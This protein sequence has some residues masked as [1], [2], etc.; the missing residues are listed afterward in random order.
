MVNA[1]KPA[2]LTAG[3]GLLVSCTSPKTPLNDDN[4]WVTIAVEGDGPFPPN[5][6]SA[7]LMLGDT[8]LL[9]DGG[10][11]M[12][13]KLKRA[14]WEPVSKAPTRPNPP[15]L[16]AAPLDRDDPL[17]IGTMRGI[18]YKIFASSESRRYSPVLGVRGPSIGRWARTCAGDLLVAPASVSS[19]WATADSILASKE[20]LLVLSRSADSVMTF[21]GFHA[22]D[23]KNS[24]S[25]SLRP[26]WGPI[27]CIGSTEY[28]MDLFGGSLWRRVGP[29]SWDSVG[30]IDPGGR[31]PRTRERD[32]AMF[33]EPLVLV[34]TRISAQ[35]FAA[36]RATEFE[37]GGPIWR[38]DP[39]L[40]KV[41]GYTVE[42]YDSALTCRF[43][44]RL[45]PSVAW[46]A[47]TGNDS[48]LVV[49]GVGDGHSPTVPTLVK[50]VWK[51]DRC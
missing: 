48:L 7:L 51:S 50:S 2:L 47:L 15:I 3:V 27:G 32:G 41:T 19:L 40:S 12:T 21:A 18:I 23:L 38:R 17:L 9:A 6:P 28:V 42:V 13:F 10:S 5:A 49:G 29:A 33:S 44:K 22:T 35:F 36:L 31:V 34:V 20:S 45:S 25:G 8:L 43:T 46:R 39:R 37:V 14:G 4:S 26:A 16:L 30:A 1:S 24:A 11:N